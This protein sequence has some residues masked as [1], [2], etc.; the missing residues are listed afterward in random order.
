MSSYNKLNNILGWLIFGI[1]LL[2]YTLTVEPTASFWDCGEFIAAAYK[3]Q[4]PHPPGAPLFLMIG[5]VFSFFAGGDVTKVAFWVNMVSVV[6]SAFTILFLFWTITLLARK[7]VVFQDGEA[8][9]IQKILV[10]GA[11]TVGALAYTFSDSFWFSAAEAEVYAISAFFTAFVV[12]AIL[13]WE[14]MADQPDS[15]RWLLLIAYMVGL[16][17]GV[18]LLNL[19]AIPSLG[20]VFYFRKY[21]PT[22]AGIAATLGI[23]A[24]ILGAILIGVIP[25]L[26]SMAGWFEILFVNS[27]GLPFKSGIT[28][29]VVIF[30]GAI[31]YGIIYS[32]KKNNRVLNLALLSFVFVLIGYSS[33]T[34]VLVRSN[35]NPPIDENNPEDIM[36]FISY[37]KREQYGDRPLFYGPQF[38]ADLTEQNDGAALYKKGE[39]DYEIYDYRTENIFDPNHQTL[40]PRM[41]SQQPHHVAEYKK[42]LKEYGGWREG[43]KPS[44]YHNIRYMLDRQLGKMYWRYF[45]WNF[46]GREGDIQDSDELWPWEAGEKMPEL[47]DSNARNNY[48][49]LPLI[50]GIAGL[51][52]QYTKEKKSFAIT[53]LLFFFTG[54]AIILYLNAP[55]IEPRERDYAYAGSYYAFCIWIGLGV[56]AVFD[57]LKEAIKNHKAL[58]ALSLAV[59]LLVPTVMAVQG[60]DDHDRSG[61]YH[62]VDSAKNLLNSCKP[63]AILF[64]GGDNDTFPLWYVQEVEG[65][66]TDVR[67][68]NLSLLNTDWYIDQ[69]KKDAYDSKA[70]PISLE[71]EDYI[72]GTNDVVYYNN[73]SGNDQPMYVDAYIKAIK[74]ENPNIRRYLQTDRHKKYINALPSK[75]LVVRMDANAV[76]SKGIVPEKFESRVPNRLAWTLKRNSLEKKDL[77]ILDMI[78]NIAKDNWERPIYFSTTLGNSNYLDLKNHMYLEG[79]AY[80]LLPANNGNDQQGTI[81]T[82]VM[83]DNMMNNMFWRGMA[84]EGVFYDE[85]YKRMVFNARLQYYFLAA[86][87]IYVENDKERGKAVINKSLEV[88]PDDVFAMEIYG[89]QY[90][91]LLFEVDDEEKAMEIATAMGDRSVEMI[92]YMSGQGV[93]RES[94]YRYYAVL[95]TIA[96]TLE[97]NGKTEEAKKYAAWLQ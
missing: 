21:K 4:I 84:D 56:I 27:F 47:L 93:S 65:F 92:E 26:P 33:Y 90:V 75:N 17:I 72:Q 51:L 11:G 25:G 55:P 59:S 79:L 23:S 68:C 40:L 52:F 19:V 6:S 71:N 7:L 44:G 78:S 32:V 77:I 66:R 87:L 53:A 85:N 95:N 8:T 80:R 42:L 54:I 1:A 5:R 37:L 28:F 39:E 74:E 45:L 35:F 38:T 81:N 49:M 12:W 91:G 36:K 57:L 31:V 97:Q 63:N 61:R 18:H 67:V 20:L 16:S 82:D 58:A 13:K 34:M 86:H 62:S 30:I 70:L 83:Y 60:W 9:L 89:A 14:R 15:D 46:V 22:K 2:V 43:K 48:W 94:M 50:L 3:L 73:P 41:H 69:M 24:L 96:K 29:F 10:L 64:T 88:M 76:K